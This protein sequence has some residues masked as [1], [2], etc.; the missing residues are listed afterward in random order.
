MDFDNQ[1][2]SESNFL[3]LCCYEVKEA[4]IGLYLSIR[5]RNESSINDLNEDKLD[6]EKEQ[7]RHIDSLEIIDH[8][9][10]TIEILIFMDDEEIRI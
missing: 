3:N 2:N 1:Q 6:K 4:L 9:K 8:I 10:K 7:L 5:L